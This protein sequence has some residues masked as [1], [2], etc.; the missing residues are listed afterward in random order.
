[1]S[2]KYLFIIAGILIVL[3]GAWFFT[4]KN[5][6]KKPTLPFYGFDRFDST[7]IKGSLK[8]DTIYHKIPDFSFVSQTGD[9][10]SVKS[11][12]NKIYVADFFFVNC[13]GICVKMAKQM[14]RVYQ[15][16]KD[17]PNVVILSHTVNPEQDSVPV[18]LNYAQ[19]QGV[20]DQKKWIFLTGSKPELYQMARLGYYVTA[21][22]GDGGTDDFVHT[23]KFVLVDENRYIRGYYDGTDEN[24]INK[25]LFDTDI[26]LEEQKRNLQN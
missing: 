12:E 20:K 22:E 14:Q 21:T 9:S 18:L 26:L 23:E 15:A 3:A 13:S 4:L 10:V 17:N 24:D 6:I 7:T 19:K 2:T 1:M 11:I 5:P 8:I 16:Y 25:L